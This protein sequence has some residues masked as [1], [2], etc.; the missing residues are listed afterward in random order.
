MTNQEAHDLERELDSYFTKLAWIESPQQGGPGERGCR[1]LAALRDSLKGWDNA[2]EYKRERDSHQRELDS[3]K[4][5]S[6][7]SS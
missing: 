5:K 4:E 6:G 1:L 2:E 7:K 3:L